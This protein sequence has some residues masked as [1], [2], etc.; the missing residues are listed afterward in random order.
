MCLAQ[1]QAAFRSNVELVVVP[2][3]VVD[4]S[5]KI[6]TGLSRDDFQVYD[7]DA[8]RA[9]ESFSV[10]DDQPLTL[11]VLIDDSESQREQAAEHRQTAKQLMQRILR[12]G[13][14]GFVISVGESVRLWAD[15]T[16]TAA[17]PFGQQWAISGTS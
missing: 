11:G 9:I 13:D 15:L 1:N 6:V 2:A 14:Q 10:D 3:T 16:G 4:G 7:N 5:G 8:R 17:E 12:E